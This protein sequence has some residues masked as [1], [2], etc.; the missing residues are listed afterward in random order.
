MI[1]LICDNCGKTFTREKQNK[2]VKH[3]FCCR[4]CKY[5]FQKRETYE[6]LC[7]AVGMDLKQFLYQKYVNESTTVRQLALLIYG[8]GKNSAV[9]LDWLHHFN[10]PLRHGSEAIKTQWINNDERRKKTSEMARKNFK[11]EEAKR[12]IAL[13]VASPEY[14]EKASAAKRGD[15]N[16][17]YG[18]CGSLH[19]NYNPNL[20]DEDRTVKRHTLEDKAFRLSVF[21]RDNFTCQKCGDNRGGNLEAHHIL[22]HWKHKNLRYDVDNG[23]TLCKKCHIEFHKKFGYKE[24]NFE[25]MVTWLKEPSYIGKKLKIDKN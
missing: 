18:K 19:P 25:Q 8:N 13:T 16:P 4:N 6:R 1:E 23:I 12:K 3:C 24:N 14:H 9:V 5:E 21:E 2:R 15:K 7:K 20:T 10:I 22:N 17:M 11:S